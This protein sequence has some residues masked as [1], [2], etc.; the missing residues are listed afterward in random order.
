M[1]FFTDDHRVGAVAATTADRFG[2]AGAEQ[3]GLACLAVKV[4]RQV[5]TALP[6]VDMRYDLTFGEGAH[7][8]S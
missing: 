4:A 2:Q 1:H 5:A 3:P 7:G 6:L 8:L